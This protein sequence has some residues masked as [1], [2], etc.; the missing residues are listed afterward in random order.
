MNTQGDQV[1]LRIIAELTARLNMVY[2]E[3]AQRPTVL[4]APSVSLEHSL[5]QFL[6]ELRIKP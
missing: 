1:L 3:V 6:V 5:A 2:L 4:A